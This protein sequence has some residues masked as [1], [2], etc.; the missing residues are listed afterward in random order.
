VVFFGAHSPTGLLYEIV[1]ED[2]N[3]VSNVT[4]E[5]ILADFAANT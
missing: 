5:S 4:M 2:L 3:V 1:D